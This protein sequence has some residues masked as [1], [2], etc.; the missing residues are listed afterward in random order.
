MTWHAMLTW[1]VLACA[2]AGAS[3]Q[4]DASF[5]SSLAVL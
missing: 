3:A 1:I 5:A 2:S 4:A